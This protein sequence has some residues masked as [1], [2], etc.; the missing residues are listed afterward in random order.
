VGED[1]ALL[2]RVSRIGGKPVPLPELL[3]V[4]LQ[5]GEQRGVIG[6]VNAAHADGLDLAANHGAEESEFAA[7]TNKGHPLPRTITGDG[8]FAWR[9]GPQ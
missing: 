5:I 9:C 8:Q 1:V 2:D 7:S 4:Q 6:A 3:P